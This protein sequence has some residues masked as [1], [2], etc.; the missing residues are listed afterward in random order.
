[1]DIFGFYNILY[2]VIY[3]YVIGMCI[4]SIFTHKEF[5]RQ[6]GYAMIMVPFLLRVLGI[7]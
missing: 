5:Q 6:I 2:R 4:W 1:M 7:K 3:I